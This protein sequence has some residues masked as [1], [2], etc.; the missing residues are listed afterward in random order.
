MWVRVPIKTVFCLSGN[1][2][3]RNAYAHGES[4]ENLW[5]IA[6]SRS[7]LVRMGRLPP[8]TYPQ[9]PA[10]LPVALPQLAEPLPKV[11]TTLPDAPLP[12]P[13]RACLWRH[14]CGG[15]PVEACL[16]RHA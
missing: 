16:W 6:E 3:F 1:T 7:L 8:I 15:M 4:V 13:P 10:G 12:R 5:A 11:P 14:A 9:V 2:P